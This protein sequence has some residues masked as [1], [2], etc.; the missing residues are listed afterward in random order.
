MTACLDLGQLAFS[1]IGHYPASQFVIVGLKVIQNDMNSQSIVI[2]LASP[3]YKFFKGFR[4]S[5]RCQHTHNPAGG[6]LLHHTEII[7]ITGR[8]YRLKD[9]TGNSNTK[10]DTAQKDKDDNSTEYG[11]S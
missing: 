2:K 11:N 9:R 4:R 5:V 1:K 8:S 3:L 7:T 6:Y 10:E